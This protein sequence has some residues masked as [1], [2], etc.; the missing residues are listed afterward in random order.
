MSHKFLPVGIQNFEK[1]ITGDFLYKEYPIAQI[2]GMRL[3]EEWLSVYDLDRFQL[4]PLLFQI[5]Y[6]TI[7]GYEDEL[8]RMDYPNQEVKTAFLDYLLKHPIPVHDIRPLR[9]RL[10]LRR[11]NSGMIEKQK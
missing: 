4:E 9:S 10:P 7:T 6:I 2:E 11:Q 1:I 5:G 3:P 8:F